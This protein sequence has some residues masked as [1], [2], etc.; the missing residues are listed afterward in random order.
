MLD[1]KKH[2]GNFT[3]FGHQSYFLD[4]ID[5]KLINKLSFKTIRLGEIKPTIHLTEPVLR[6][7]DIVSI[8]MSSVKQSD[9]PGHAYPSPNGF[10][11]DEICQ[12]AKYAG[13]SDRVGTFGIYEINPS[14]DINSQTTHLAAQMIWIFIESVTQRFNENPKINSKNI[15]KFIIHVNEVNREVVFYKSVKSG[16]WWI[17]VYVFSGDKEY[18]KIIACAE[19]DYNMACKNELPDRWLKAFQLSR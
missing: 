17:E 1:K 4:Q 19:E 2:L 11:G 12:I 3:N 5:L 8:D 10:T 7:A 14:F 15:K 6:D 18:S 13:L 16:R 9:A